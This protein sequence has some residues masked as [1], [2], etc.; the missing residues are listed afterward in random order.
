MTVGHTF[1]TVR[2]QTWPNEMG[3]M[4]ILS[5]SKIVHSLSWQQACCRSGDLKA[6]SWMVGLCLTGASE[7]KFSEQAS[8]C[9][10]AGIAKRSDMGSCNQR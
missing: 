2:S 6:P 4:L 7:Q 3:C 5:S 1:A 10:F 8:N 9:C